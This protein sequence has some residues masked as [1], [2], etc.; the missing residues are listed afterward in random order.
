MMRDAGLEDCRYHNLSGGIVAA[1]SRL[2]VLTCLLAAPRGSLL[3]R[4]VADSRRRRRCVAQLD[5][6]VVC[7]RRDRHAAGVLCKRAAMVGCSL[8]DKRRRRGRRLA[9]G[10]TVSLLLARRSSRRGRAG[11]RRRTHR[12]RRRGRTEVPRTASPAQPDLEEE[13]ARVV[14]DVAARNLAN[15]ARGFLDFGRKAGRSL[16]GNVSEYL[17][18]EG[19][20]LPTT[21]EAEEFLAGV[22]R[23]RDDVERLEA[24]LA[25]LGSRGAKGGAKRPRLD[26]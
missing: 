4:N 17:Q 20:D 7:A 12:G 22:D 23:L 1:A 18:E 14:G 8:A 3:N 13:L 26:R 21:T 24:R 16:A 9:V 25:R 2:P 11:R 6:R 5:G 10:I 15:L 19:R